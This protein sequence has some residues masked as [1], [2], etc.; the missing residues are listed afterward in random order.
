MHLLT[1]GPLTLPPLQDYWLREVADHA[2]EDV[3]KMLC[4]NKADAVGG[5]GSVARCL[6]LVLALLV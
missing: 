4:G 6:P 2:A 3:V 5:G 1:G